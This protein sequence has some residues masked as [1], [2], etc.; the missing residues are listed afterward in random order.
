MHESQPFIPFPPVCLSSPFHLSVKN[1]GYPFQIPFVL[2]DEIG[3]FTVLRVHQGPF[4]CSLKYQHQ[5]SKS[6]NNGK[7][8]NH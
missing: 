1:D 6:I 2:L 8:D 5:V 7:G 4:M 3:S